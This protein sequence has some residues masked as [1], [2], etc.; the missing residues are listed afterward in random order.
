MPTG[1]AKRD[2]RVNDVLPSPLSPQR[3]LACLYIPNLH[4]RMLDQL[5]GRPSPSWRRTQVRLPTS[6]PSR[7][8]PPTPLDT[9][10]ARGCLHTGLPRPPLLGVS[11]RTRQEGGSSASL[12]SST[13]SPAVEVHAVASDSVNLDVR[14]RY[15][16]C[17]RHAWTERAGT[18]CSSLL[19]GLLSVRFQLFLTLS[20]SRKRLED[21]PKMLT[22]LLRSAT[23]IVT[24]LDAGFAT[25]MGIKWKWLRDLASLAFSGYYL[26]FA[27]EADEKVRSTPLYP[28][29]LPPTA[30]FLFSTQRSDPF[31]PR[32][33]VSTALSAPSRC[34][35]RRGRRRATLTSSSRLGKTARR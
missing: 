23:W 19:E 13:E 21:G 1:E 31:L 22:I 28:L 18:A 35:G 10:T 25:A 14:I 30:F 4:K 5:A 8:L 26:L 15:S 9:L 24:A 2:G 16:P 27:H 7:L 20:A 34:S 11:T 32:R 17:R 6:L 3:L 12:H 33:S 29:F